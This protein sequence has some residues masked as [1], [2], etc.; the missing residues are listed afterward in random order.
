MG[1]QIAPSAKAA[2]TAAAHPT[3][4]RTKTAAVAAATLCAPCSVIVAM[5]SNWSAMH[6][7]KSPSRNVLIAMAHPALDLSVSLGT[8]FAMTPRPHLTSTAQTTIMMA[9]IV[10]RMAIP[11]T[12]VALVSVDNWCPTLTTPGVGNCSQPRI[13]LAATACAGTTRRIA[14]VRSTVQIT[15]TAAMTTSKRAKHAFLHLATTGTTFPKNATAG[16]TSRVCRTRTVAKTTSRS[17]TPKKA[18][19]RVARVLAEKSAPVGAGV[20]RFASTTTTAAMTTKHC[21][22][23]ESIPTNRALGA[24]TVAMPV[25]TTLTA[26]STMAVAHT[27]STVSTATASA[28]NAL[29]VTVSAVVQSTWMLATSVCSRKTGVSPLTVPVFASVL[30]NMTSVEFAVEPRLLHSASARILNKNVI[31]PEHA[32]VSRL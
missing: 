29:T 10:R 15:M 12:E 1:K 2:L 14:I 5:T 32:T 16:V 7:Q 20:T 22:A 6:T 25:T 4:P 13:R 23:A 18:W 31:A 21:V 28:W 24:R 9:A 17:V 11:S 30:P 3:E 27:Q 8:A 19:P 26:P